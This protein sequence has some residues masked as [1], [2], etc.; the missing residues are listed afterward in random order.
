ME[1]ED[2]P[3]GQA[4]RAVR[5][6]RAPEDGPWPGVLVRTAPGLSS[7]L[8]DAEVLGERWAGW[9]AGGEGHVLAPIDIARRA[10]GHDAV[11]PVCLERL[12]DFIRRR[13]AR[14]PLGPG[15]AVTLAV[16]VMRGCAELAGSP[17]IRGEWWLDDTGRPVLATDASEERVRDASAA[18]LDQVTVAPVMKRTWD[19]AVR[20]IRADRLSTVELEAAEEALFA[21]AAAEPLVTMSLHPRRAAE[22]ASATNAGG[23]RRIVEEPPARS[24]WQSLL[25][26][27]DDELADT[28]SRATTGVWR[29][30]R[31]ADR[32]GRRPSRRAPWLVAGAVG[33]AVLTGGALWPTA[34]GISTAG[35]AATAPVASDGDQTAVTPDP[36]GAGGG[37]GSGLDAG[38]A[39]VTAAADLATIAAGL[40]DA[41]R[42]CDDEAACVAGVAV[43]GASVVGG[44]V[45]LPAQERTVTLLDDFG[46]LAVVRV[47]PRDGAGPAQLV[48]IVRQDAGWLLRDVR[49]VAQQP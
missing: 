28:V 3:L 2:A 36:Q 48:V 25:R 18:L 34:N 44:A 10:D 46:D 7:V 20:A 14:L 23:H 30:L 41:R 9:D 31:P 32:T 11:L 47:D 26:G 45:D 6:V 24:L 12:D 17:D 29:R 35:P 39:P 49:D 4:Y 22:G 40:L 16:S 43:D 37:E 21:L 19:T 13:E 8:V 33:A 15:E 1:T 5:A 27:V 42:E 38:T